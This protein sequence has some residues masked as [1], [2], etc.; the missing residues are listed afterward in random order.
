MYVCIIIRLA[1]SLICSGLHGC[2]FGGCSSLG[3]QWN[4]TILGSLILAESFTKRM[5][6]EVEVVSQILDGK[7][8]RNASI[9]AVCDGAGRGVLGLAAVSSVRRGVVVAAAAA[10]EAKRTATTSRIHSAEAAYNQRK[11]RKSRSDF[12]GDGSQWSKHGLR[13]PN[14]ASFFHQN[15]KLLGLGR[16]SGQINFGAFGVF[17]ADLSAP[18]LVQ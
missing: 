13:T 1:Y 6:A 12:Q 4:G 18:I 10:S 16:Q 17:S 3:S 8:P 7:V 5:L 11:S 15:P 2:F 9:A 14:E